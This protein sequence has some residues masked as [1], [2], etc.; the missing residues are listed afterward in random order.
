MMAIIDFEK[1]SPFQR[2]QLIDSLARRV[3]QK[4]E[5]EKPFEQYLDETWRNLK[6]SQDAL[7]NDNSSY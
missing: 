4:I 3:A 7:K 1:L 6:A 5:Q 2:K